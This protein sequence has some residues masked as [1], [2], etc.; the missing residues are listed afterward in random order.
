MPAV[1]TSFT[2]AV[3]YSFRGKFNTM[4]DFRA[5]A[6]AIVDNGYRPADFVGLNR[7]QTSA[8]LRA[9]TAAHTDLITSFYQAIDLN[10]AIANQPELMHAY[11]A[12]N[13]G[14][15]PNIRPR[16]LCSSLYVRAGMAN[17]L[18]NQQCIDTAT[19]FVAEYDLLIA[20]L[21]QGIHPRDLPQ[22]LVT[23]FTAALVRFLTE[24]YSTYYLNKRTEL[25][26]H[27]QTLGRLLNYRDAAAADDPIVPR[28]N[29]LLVSTSDLIFAL[30]THAPP[31][32][33]NLEERVAFIL[34]NTPALM[35][36]TTGD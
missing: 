4:A 33:L 3:F 17:Q 32:G 9:G 21:A 29:T 15:Q 5:L 14:Q 7:A 2:R 10:A 23:A 13:D 36:G 31:P 27:I 20:A 30:S 19:A 28:V 35:A 11:R 24:M 18:P 22:E 6:A 1:S 26:N 16:V 25:A 8:R 12:T 34:N